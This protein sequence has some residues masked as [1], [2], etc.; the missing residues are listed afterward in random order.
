MGLPNI[1]CEHPLWPSLLARSRGSTPLRPASALRKTVPL[2]LIKPDANAGDRRV[3]QAMPLP[4]GP[5][6]HA[7]IHT[8]AELLPPLEAFAAW[9][10]GSAFRLSQLPARHDFMRACCA[11]ALLGLGVLSLEE[12]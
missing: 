3:A 12:G 2:K 9:P 5:G 1:A 11:R 6:R 8:A 4:G 7:Y 10:V